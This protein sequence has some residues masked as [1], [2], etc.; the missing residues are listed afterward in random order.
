[1]AKRE[2]PSPHFE[3]A[4]ECKNPSCSRIHFV[5][6]TKAGK[7]KSESCVILHQ[8]EYTEHRTKSKGRRGRKHA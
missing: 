7:V 8:F 2:K 4:L 6:R 5:Y 1:M 3:L